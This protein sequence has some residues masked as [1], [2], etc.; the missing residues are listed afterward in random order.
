MGLA[1]DDLPIPVA[2]QPGIGNMITRAQ[3]LTK[4]CLSLV[5]VVTKNRHVIV[6]PTLYT[7]EFDRT[8]IPG[9]QRCDIR[10]QLGLIHGASFFIRENGIVGEILLPG[11]L[12]ARN[13]GIVQLLRPPNQFV[14]GNG[15]VSLSRG[16]EV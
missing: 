8:G 7:L 10:N 5:S 15:C 11:S 16:S 14:L 6:N 1:G 9:W 12:V 3:I 2:S 4:N 13:D